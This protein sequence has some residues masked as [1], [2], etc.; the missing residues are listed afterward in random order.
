[1]NISIQKTINEK[2]L[3][4]KYK[5]SYILAFIDFLVH[6][7][8]LCCSFY[9]VYYFRNSYLSIL[10][11][12]L[13]GLLHIK[14]FIIFHDC[15]HNSYTPNK[16]L[17]YIIGVITGILTNSPFSW[18]F[19]HN[20][21]HLTNG[22]VNNIYDYPYNDTIF[23]SYKEYKL[24]S[25]IKKNIYKLLRQ[26]YTFFS[27]VP[28][29]QFLIILRFNIFRLN[30]QFI[31]NKNN[32]F[33]VEQIINNIGIFILFYY[34]YNN[35]ILLHIFISYMIASSCGIA[36]FHCQHAFNPPYVVINETWNMKNSGLVGSSF[37]QIP[38]LLKYFTGNIE[39]HHIHH[40]NAKIPSYNLDKYHNDVVS[41]SDLFN[42]VIKLSMIDCYNSL[43][44]VLYDEDE[45]QYITF[46]EADNKIINDKTL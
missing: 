40:M 28:I 33:I 44:L 37:I 32:Y 6:T 42:N 38:Y 31:T 15:G 8:I 22:N 9:L 11:I 24:I 18:N 43:W 17:N 39:Y 20:I 21:H 35:H 2:E 25:P 41:K 46:M 34:Y 14:T 23:H 30:K 36:L 1:M 16:T 7:I 10:T 26:P 5:S 12:P 4:M 19:N 3:F 27:C 13:L 45:K 29:F